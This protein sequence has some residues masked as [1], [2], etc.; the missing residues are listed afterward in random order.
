MVSLYSHALLNPL[1]DLYIYS[2]SKLVVLNLKKHA[3]IF[4]LF[5]FVYSYVCVHMCLYLQIMS[6]LNANCFIL[7][8]F[9]CLLWN[10]RQIARPCSFYCHSLMSE[11]C[12]LAKSRP[13]VNVCWMNKR[14]PCR[15]CFLSR[16]I[17]SHQ[18]FYNSSGE[19][20]L[21]PADF[22]LFFVCVCVWIGLLLFIC[23]TM[24]IFYW[25]IVD[26]QY[27]ISFRYT[28]LWFSIL[29]VILH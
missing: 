8:P 21:Q 29:Q 19:P 6:I 25:S 12:C 18:Y 7:F 26:L 22:S 20:T 3:P 11:S 15:I 9:N 16:Y 24:F 17:L 14:Q 1:T 13:S 4:F 27:Y 2:H 10:R 5:C 28:A 23:L